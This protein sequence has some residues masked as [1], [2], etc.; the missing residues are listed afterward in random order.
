MPCASDAEC[1]QWQPEARC[2]LAADG[3][4][5]HCGTRCSSGEDC[6][7]GFVC[8]AFD[9]GPD[10]CWPRSGECACTGDMSGAQLGCQ[11]LAPGSS[12][13]CPGSRQCSDDGVGACQ[14]A[15]TESCNGEDDDCDGKSDEDFTDLSGR[16]VDAD[17]C[18]R[19]G[20]PCVAQGP[21]ALATC[22]PSENTAVCRQG[23]EA[24]FVDVDGLAADGCECQLSTA[25]TPVIEGDQDCD[26]VIDP[27]P[28]LIFVSAGGDDADDGTTPDNAVQTIARGMALGT[29]FERT[30]VV[31]RGIYR[32]RLE[33]PSGVT[34][35]GGYSPDFREHDAELYPVMIEAP[36]GDGGAPVLRCT[37]IAV[38]TYLADMTIAASDAGAPGVGSTA[39]FFSN[40]SDAVELNN[41]TVLSA[42]GAAGERGADSSQRL[43]ERGLSSLSELDGVSGT[44]GADG[45]AIGCALVVAGGGGS[46]LCSGVDVSG[47]VGGDARCAALSCSNDDVRP[48]GNAGCS[49][50]TSDGVCDIDAARRA[51]VANP[52]PQPGRG[53]GAGLAG[54]ATYDAPTDHGTCTFCDDNPS[55]PRVGGAGGDGLPGLAGAA[56]QGCGMEPELGI[57]GRLRALAGGAGDDGGDGAGGGGGSAGAGYA[58]IAGTE[59]GCSSVAGAAGGGGGSG[60]CGAPAAAGGGG[61]GAS[62][63]IVIV[64][65]SGDMRG[66]LL[67]DVR[68]VTA[69]GGD[70]GDGG[71]GAAGGA[72]GSGG[73]GGV[74]DFWCARNGGRGG[75]GGAGGDGGGG[76]GG[77]GGSSFGVYV[78]QPDSNTSADYLMDVTHNTRIEVAGAAGRAGRGGFSPA[79][80]GGDGRAGVAIALAHVTR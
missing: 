10:Q 60:G 66:P 34:M 65:A 5:G 54:A 52:P 56:G 22:M 78:V 24:G 32:E 30:V 14:P 49:D 46:K 48:C 67:R 9:G 7:T 28:Q 58:V 57:D 39:V 2:I 27:V 19:C 29:L 80:A 18:G 40:C 74:S 76:G 61:G 12:R 72:G 75:D 11:L 23:C 47:G 71:V 44:S 21:H 3:G 77:C 35:V 33:L 20:S 4:S 70:G 38:P 36:L 53:T 73:L 79:H 45:G 31:A 42:R 69:S 68:V 16:Y 59:G 43:V 55:L 41:V 26:G 63:G 15:L 62:V 1:A 17:N 37:D 50:F 8:K 51:A 6:G 13:V 64:L 25:R